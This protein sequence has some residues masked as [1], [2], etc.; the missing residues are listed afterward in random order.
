MVHGP[1]LIP[2]TLTAKGLRSVTWRT[3]TRTYHDC[4]QTTARVT[5]TSTG[6]ASINGQPVSLAVAHATLRAADQR[7]VIERVEA[8]EGG[9]Q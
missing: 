7:E 1:S 8:A 3:A 4:G 5:V 6:E 2:T 9:A